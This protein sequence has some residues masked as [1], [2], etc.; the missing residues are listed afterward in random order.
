MGK[1]PKWVVSALKNLV[2]SLRIHFTH[3]IILFPN[4]TQ[5]GIKYYFCKKKNTK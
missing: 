4:Y 1:V 2:K 5:I 3:T